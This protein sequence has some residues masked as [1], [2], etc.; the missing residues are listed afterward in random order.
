MGVLAV[1]AL[2]AVMHLL[3]KVFI[4]LIIAGLISLMLSPVVRGLQRLR[5]PRLAAILLVL[6]ALLVILYVV[7]RLFYSSLVSFT[8]VFGG[9]QTRFILILEDVW[10]R[11]DIPA[12]YFPKL[13]W[14]QG[15]IDRIV[16]ITGSFVNFGVYLGLVLLFLMFMLLENTLSWRKFR[17]AFPRNVSVTLGKAVADVTRQVARYLTI[18]TLISAVTGLLVWL[19]LRLIGQDL[20][21][22]WGMMAFLLN[23]IPNL[24][25]FLIMAATMTLGLAQFYPEWDKIAAA[26]VAMP[27]IQLLMGNILDPA[28][29]GDQLDLSPLVILVSLVVWGWI[30]GIIGMF[31]AVPLTVGLKIIMAHFEVLKPFSVLMG[32]GRMSRSFRRQWRKKHGIGRF[33]SGKSS[34]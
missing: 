11:W 20:A 27:A 3:P 14:T 26:W 5:V 16:A 22:L 25:S 29:Q 30:W 13:G 1:L 34:K 9:Y 19:S 31:L 4:P 10:V 33:C 18:K 12:E 21:A 23:Y 17:R 8:Q 32:S 2:G 6:A 24:G 7:G 15:L 28:L